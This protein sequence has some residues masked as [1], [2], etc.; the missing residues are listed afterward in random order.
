MTGYNPGTANLADQMT[1]GGAAWQSWNQGI[2]G[3]TVISNVP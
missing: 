2:Y 3:T 1:N